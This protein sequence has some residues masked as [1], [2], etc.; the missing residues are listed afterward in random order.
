[1]TSELKS[2]KTGLVLCGGGGK[3]AYQVGVLKALKEQGLLDDVTAISGASIGAVN[4]VLYAMD[5]IQLMYDAW[6][7]MDMR[8]LFDVDLELLIERNILFSRD[9][10]LKLISK[11]MDF[12]KLKNSEY[13]IYASIC[14]IVPGEVELKPEYRKLTDYDVNTTKNILLASTALPLIYESVEIDGGFYRDGGICDNTPIKPLY[15]A[16]IRRFIV[17]CMKQ[18]KQINESNWPDAEFITI[19]PS[20]DLGKLVEGTLN[21]SEKAIDFRELLGYKDGLR[22]AKTKFSKD[23]AYIKIEPTL[24]ASDYNEIIMQ[25]RVDKTYNE[26]G[27]RINKNIEKFNKLAEKYDKI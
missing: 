5:D 19:T 12:D 21:F 20:R 9:E 22:S 13:D 16:G 2:T 11:Y 7:D 23:E 27:S 4:A 25:M 1:M 26:V 8:T 15:D 24:A 17:I 3:G 18:N 6:D 14:K 10:T